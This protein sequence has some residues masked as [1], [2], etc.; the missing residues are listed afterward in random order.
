MVRAGP[1]AHFS[2]ARS[3]KGID[4][5]DKD[6]AAALDLGHLAGFLK[7]AF[8][9]GGADT[10]EHADELAAD[11]GEKG[12]AGFGRD[13]LGE[14]GLSAAG[15]ADKE[16]SF[17]DISTDHVQEFAVF[18]ELNNF[19]GLFLGLLHADDLIPFDIG[20]GVGSCVAAQEFGDPAAH[21]KEVED[22][23]KRDKNDALDDPHKEVHSH[24]GGHLFPAEGFHLG[25][26][27]E[28]CKQ[29]GNDRKYKS[30]GNKDQEIFQP[31]HAKIFY[32]FYY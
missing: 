28:T 9:A 14:I 29:H 4:L 10:H 6:D 18:E 11:R 20:L 1:A 12:Q 3:G 32:E 31:V 15:A 23:V 7:K 30:H 5:V 8:H 25:E 2:L 22:P 27:G 21:H 24:L 13:G 17:N 26:T 16:R 19:P